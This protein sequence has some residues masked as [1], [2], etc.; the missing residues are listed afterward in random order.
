MGI[1]QPGKA[2]WIMQ[3]YIFSILAL[4]C[5]LLLLQTD[6]KGVFSTTLSEEY[7]LVAETFNLTHQ[8]V[9]NLTYSSI[10][11]IFAEES[12]KNALKE[13]WREEGEHL[14]NIK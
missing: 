5:P 7:S 10:N 8:Q 2:P 1:T 4:L 14:M 11:Y 13:I 12:V 3:V 9:W 6:D